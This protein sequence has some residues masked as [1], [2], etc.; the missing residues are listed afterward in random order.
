MRV[1][2][3]SLRITKWTWPEQAGAHKWLPPLPPG[4]GAFRQKKGSAQGARNRGL[5]NFVPRAQ[6]SSESMLLTFPSWNPSLNQSVN[7]KLTTKRGNLRGFFF[8][9]LLW[10][11]AFNFTRVFSTAVL[12][13]YQRWKRC[14]EFSN[15]FNEYLQS[16]ALCQALV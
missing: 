4:G 7:Q 14:K 6:S 1:T 16:F 13:L 3:Q 2:K 15:S 12:R 8:S 10:F 9:S 5:G 11:L